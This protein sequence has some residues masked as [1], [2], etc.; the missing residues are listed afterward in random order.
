MLHA[1]FNLQNICLHRQSLH[2]IKRIEN[3]LA[4]CKYIDE[5]EKYI[6]KIENSSISGVLEE[7][8]KDSITLIS[9]FF[10]MSVKSLFQRLALIFLYLLSLELVIFL[11]CLLNILWT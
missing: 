1:D 9:L 8:I 3:I 10:A 11:F 4:L 2:L 5:E 6:I 7:E